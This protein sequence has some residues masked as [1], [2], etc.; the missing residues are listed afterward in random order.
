M[1]SR[2]YSTQVTSTIRKYEI[3]LTFSDDEKIHTVF[4][5]T[6]GILS[7][8][9]FSSYTLYLEADQTVQKGRI[10]INAITNRWPDGTLQWKHV[11]GLQVHH[12]YYQEGAMPWDYP[13]RD[14]TTLCWIC[15]EK[16]HAKEKIPFL[17][18]DGFEKGSLT[19]CYRCHSAGYFPEYNHVEDGICFRCRGARYEE[20][21]IHADEK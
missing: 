15:H 9:D 7:Q 12:S 10:S 5:N 4:L 21:I 11:R 19:P 6:Y 17:D 1:G 16:L 20:H 13:D 2:E 18:R 3:R 8:R 14:L